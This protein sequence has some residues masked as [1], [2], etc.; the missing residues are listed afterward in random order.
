VSKLT[1]ESISTI[2]YVTVGLIAAVVVGC[3]NYQR[4]F[5]HLP[6]PL[7]PF[8]VVGFT[9]ALMYA[10]VQ[11]RRAGL[12][13]LMIV[14]L[15][16][17]QVAMTPPIRSSSLAAG[18]IFA[19]PVGFALLAGSYAQKALARFKIGRFIVM[20]TIVAVGYGLM[21]VLFLIHSHTGIRMVW[22]RTQ[23]LV[24]LELG[25]AMGLGF[26]LVDILG[27]RLKHQPKQPAP[28]H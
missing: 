15:Y 19:L 27:P 16:L 11:L 3:I 4:G 23:A 26:E 24:G 18:A 25:A 14:L 21:M 28:G 17:S 8:L 10:T 22:V 20:G 2:A 13:I 12:A 7:L 9:G 1:R 6:R 5:F